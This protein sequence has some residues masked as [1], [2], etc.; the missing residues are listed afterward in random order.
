MA[1]LELTIF[2]FIVGECYEGGTWVAFLVRSQVR[3]HV[4]TNEPI[5]Q[6]QLKVVFLVEFL[7][8]HSLR[9]GV[10]IALVALIGKS[11]RQLLF[12]LKA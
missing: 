7:A 12:A 9:V 2:L 6:V 3:G 4:V 11:R 1:S 8:L 5:K 10:V